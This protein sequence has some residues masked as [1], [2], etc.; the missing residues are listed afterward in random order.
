MAEAGKLTLKQARFVRAYLGDAAG[1]ATEAARRA[2][3]AGNDHTLAAV[4]SENL[5]KPAVAA[6][7]E[8]AEGA[9]E[10]RDVARRGE[11]RAFWTS[12]FRGEVDDFEEHTTRGPDGPETSVEPAR[13]KLRD[14]LKASELLGKSRG[15]FVERRELTG[16]GGGP[17]A[18]E[19]VRVTIEDA[20][21]GA[22]P[23]DETRADAAGAPAASRPDDDD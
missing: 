4:G 18:I 19:G 16:E 23:T 1:N 15:M 22:Q 8:A 2:G 5:R 10:K 17:I 21:A 9:D 6:A 12:V 14:R 11:L 13:A 20:T 3:Y 7:I